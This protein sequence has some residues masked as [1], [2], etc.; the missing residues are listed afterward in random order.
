MMVACKIRRL[1]SGDGASRS[2][3]V[4]LKIWLMGNLHVEVEGDEIMVSRPGTTF[5]ATYGKPSHQPHLLMV[6][7]SAERGASVTS[8]YEFRSQAFQAA[9]AKARAR[10]I[11]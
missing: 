7:G 11:L 3:A 4:G 6:R 1:C 9:I 5:S 2:R 10:G 8:I